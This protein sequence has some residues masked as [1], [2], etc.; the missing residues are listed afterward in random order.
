MEKMT[1]FEKIMA[2]LKKHI[3]KIAI[4][5]H[6]FAILCVGAGIALIIEYGFN[7]D[8]ILIIALAIFLSCCTF[9]K[10]KQDIKDNQV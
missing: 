4:A 1:R 3:L 10:I 7:F 2:T 9:V 8:F 6:Y 5:I